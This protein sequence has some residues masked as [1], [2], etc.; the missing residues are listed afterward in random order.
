MSQKGT[1]LF[2]SL[3]FKGMIFKR[4]ECFIQHQISILEW[5]LKDH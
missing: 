2:K 4:N 1:A 5:F 3:G